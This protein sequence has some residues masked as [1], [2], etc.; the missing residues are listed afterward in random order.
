[1]LKTRYKAVIEALVPYG[2]QYTCLHPVLYYMEEE[3]L[4]V[5]YLLEKIEDENLEYKDF[6]L[7][8]LASLGIPDC[9]RIADANRQNE[10]ITQ[11]R[12]RR[13]GETPKIADTDPI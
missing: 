8:L 4:E 10:E 1:M 3:P 12:E 9:N 7:K 6:E 5:I 11:R 2:L 13:Q